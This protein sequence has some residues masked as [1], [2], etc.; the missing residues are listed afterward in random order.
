MKRK[1]WE[2]FPTLYRRESWGEWAFRWLVTIALVGTGPAI[3]IAATLY[4][5]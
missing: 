1:R 2:E 3:C 5:G 4:G